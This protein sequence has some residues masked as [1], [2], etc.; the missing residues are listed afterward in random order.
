MMIFRYTMPGRAALQSVRAIPN[1]RPEDRRP[2]SELIA[3]PAEQPPIESGHSRN[4]ELP[5]ITQMGADNKAGRLRHGLFPIGEYRRHLRLRNSDFG[6]LSGFGL[7]S[8]DFSAAEQDLPSTGRTIEQP[9]MPGRIFDVSQTTITPGR[10]RERG[11]SALDT[12]AACPRPAEANLP[13]TP[14][15]PG[16][17]ERMPRH[18]DVLWVPEPQVGPSPQPLRKGRGGNRRQLFGEPRFLGRVAA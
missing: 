11:E 10:K 7:R 6:L 8:S 2:K 16:S 5:P 17:G 13:K 15:K 4:S 3:T 14:A 12:P 18:S 9:C 1:P